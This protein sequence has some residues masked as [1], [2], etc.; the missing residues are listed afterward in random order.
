[1]PPRARGSEIV[2]FIGLL[3]GDHRSLVS[4][5]TLVPLGY[6]NPGN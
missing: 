2:A 4:T 1:V 5:Y 6:L 3:V